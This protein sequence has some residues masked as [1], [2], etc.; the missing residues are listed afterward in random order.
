MQPFLAPGGVLIQQ[1]REHE[2]WAVRGKILEDDRF[3][4]PVR[5]L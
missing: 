3:D 2:F 5:K 1:V 4:Y